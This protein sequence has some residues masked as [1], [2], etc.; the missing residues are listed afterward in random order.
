MRV[1]LV[2]KFWYPKGGSERY[3]F[4]LKDLLE[5]HGHEVVP[6][7]M[8][9]ERNFSTPRASYFVPHVDFWEATDAVP[10]ET[11]GLTKLRTVFWNRAAAR[12]LDELLK[13]WKPDVAHLQNFSHQISPSILPVLK[14]HGVPIVWTLHDYELLCPN[15]RMY[16]QG[17]PCER[18]RRH[19]YWNTL[20]YSCM[21][22]CAASAAV[23][24]E[25]SL[26]AALGVYCKNIDV[27][28][29]PS[30]F[31]ASKL[32]EWGWSGR[33]EVIPN[34][35]PIPPTPPTPP[36][37]PRELGISLRSRRGGKEGTGSALFVGRLMEEKG[38]EDFVEA[39]RRLPGIQFEVIG[40]GP[41]GKKFQIS[42][43]KFQTNSKSQA[44]NLPLP[45]DKFQNVQWLGARSSEETRVRIASAAMVVVPSRWYENAPYVVLEA[46]AAGVPVV[47]S[48]IGGLPELVR[49]GETG[50]LVPSRDPE[51]LA[52]A[53]KVLHN[54]PARCRAMGE[55]AR[56]IART[57]Y[58]PGRH[59]ERI[60][61]I[62][63]Q[64]AR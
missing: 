30:Q 43:T 59:Y 20:R 25:H 33:V 44:P 48:Q 11:S 34:F 26:H 14:R 4:L 12:Q 57:E 54:D 1:L 51:A 32:A 6:F 24:L 21:G 15:Y 9:D 29:A 53:I 41:L 62:Y 16:T 22:N 36:P 49:D 13:E 46:M 50:L 2:N 23:A 38:I 45:A 10:N 3:A 47:A 61:G 8:E 5:S 35:V 39:A 28:I 37:V 56:G 55:R 27:V 63:S 52:N 18:C 58:E 60:V 31:L 64:F 42:S 7:A 19:R 17:S 40:D